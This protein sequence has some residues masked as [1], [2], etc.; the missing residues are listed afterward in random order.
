MMS[1][2]FAQVIIMVMQ[3]TVSKYII[4]QD[5]RGSAIEYLCLTVIS[6]PAA[7]VQS[8]L[9]VALTGIGWSKELQTDFQCLEPDQIHSI[10]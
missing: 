10:V 8:S 9:P 7:R 3:V 1:F 6:S 4:L 5:V 2:F